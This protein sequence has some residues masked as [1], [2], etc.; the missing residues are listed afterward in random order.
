M[1]PARQKIFAVYPESIGNVN[2]SHIT[3]EC[4][5]YIDIASEDKVAIWKET[6]LRKELL[7]RV[8][9]GT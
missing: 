1:L 8:W 2:I 5:Q 7:N 9:E 6:N 3:D 4:R